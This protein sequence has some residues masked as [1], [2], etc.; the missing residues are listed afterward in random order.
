MT[1][2]VA[3]IAGGRVVVVAALV[4]LDAR[5]AAGHDLDASSARTSAGEVRLDGPAV[6]AAPVAGL[7]VAVV[8]RFA[9]IE[10]AIAASGRGRLGVARFARVAPGVPAI[11]S[12][13]QV[14]AV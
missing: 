1:V 12:G 13:V 9:A 10:G 6:A 11:E 14:A 2:A 5:V 3:A 8:A 7:C 4:A